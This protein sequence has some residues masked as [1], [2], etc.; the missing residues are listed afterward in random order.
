MNQG[1]FVALALMIA[2]LAFVAVNTRADDHKK[3]EVEY[4]KSPGTEDMNL[5][6]SAAVRVGN[7]MF[8][9]GQLGLVPGTRELAEGG[10][11]PETRQTMENIAATLEDFCSSID[12]VVKCTVFLAD[13]DEWGA[14]NEVYRTFFENAPARSALGASG[15]ALGAQVE[16][17]CIAVVD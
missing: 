17:E 2:V 11:Q 6:F 9:S 15:L 14:M 1:R 10:I 16:I 12:N 7:L 3:P 13:M 4:L 5:P 8:L